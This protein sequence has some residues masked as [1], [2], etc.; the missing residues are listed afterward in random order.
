VT[1]TGEPVVEGAHRDLARLLHERA[2]A[3][4]APPLLVGLTGAVAVGKSTTAGILRGLLAEHP[5][6]P[7]VEVVATDGFL[8]PN[9]VLDERGLA[10]RKGFPESYDHDALVAFLAAL[11]RG[12][13]DVRAPLYSHV[14]Y[15]VT[16]EVQVLVRPDVVIVEGLTVLGPALAGRFDVTIYVDADETDVEA[17]FV[18]RLV[19]LRAAAVDDEASFYRPLA[20]FSDD[21]V[22]AFAHAV[23]AS[24]NG[25]NLRENVLPGRDDADVVVEKAADHTIRGLRVRE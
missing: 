1:S 13:P 11:R 18:A 22:R 2:V 9:V 21:D 15:D 10:D 3:R 19:A 20:A 12:E 24:I 4:A 7:V 5:E 25:P 6:H 8:L 16:D 23:W 17:W 14:T